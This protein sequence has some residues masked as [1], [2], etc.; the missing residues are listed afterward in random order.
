V[1]ERSL[2]LKGLEREHLGED[3]GYALQLLIYAW[4]Y[5]TMHPNCMALRTGVVPLQRASRSD[6]IYLSIQGNDLITRAHYADLTTLLVDL[7]NELVNGTGPF[8]HSP[9]STYCK[10]CVA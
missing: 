6:G 2:D 5:L 7:T 1:K 4:T 8:T 10:C 3:H 9:N